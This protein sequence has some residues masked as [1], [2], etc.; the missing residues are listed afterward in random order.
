MRSLAFLSILRLF[1]LQHRTG[2]SN[3]M[4]SINQVFP[5]PVRRRNIG[6]IRQPQKTPPVYTGSFPTVLTP[7]TTGNGPGVA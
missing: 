7:K 6:V 1:W 5:Q 3:Y 4:F 2:N